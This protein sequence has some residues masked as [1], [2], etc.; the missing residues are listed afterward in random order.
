MRLV[1]WATLIAL[2]VGS[3]CGGK[4][5]IDGEPGSGGSASMPTV[6]GMGGSGLAGGGGSGGDFVCTAA[7]KALI[8]VYNDG[9]DQ[10]YRAAGPDPDLSVPTG[11]IVYGEGSSRTMGHGCASNSSTNN[12]ISIEAP[13]LD[14]SGAFAANVRV[15]YTS[16]QG[17]VFVGDSGTMSLDFLGPVGDLMVGSFDVEVFAGGGADQRFLFGNYALCRGPDVFLP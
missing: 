2:G 16:A 17:I 8:E 4:A 10:F 12:C 5:V 7:D 1:F 11:W 9:P 13:D 15:E 3:A 14:F 6:G